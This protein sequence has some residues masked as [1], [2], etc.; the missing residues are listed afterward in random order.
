MAEIQRDL[1]AGE[2]PD[3]KTE[4]IAESDL[5]PHT[6][7]EPARHQNPRSAREGPLADLLRRT[8]PRHERAAEP[9]PPGVDPGQR[10]GDVAD[11]VQALS[12]LHEQIGELLRACAGLLEASAMLT[13]SVGP[14][15]STS[16]VKEF[17]QRLAGMPGVAEVSVRGYE[18]DRAILDVRLA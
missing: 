15:S 14:F 12:R 7:H 11:R 5:P 3:P 4:A 1:G 2:A 9:P 8:P 10:A 16:N 18:G 6:E 13:I 17:E